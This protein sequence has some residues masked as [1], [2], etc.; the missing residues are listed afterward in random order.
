MLFLKK[1]NIKRKKGAILADAFIAMFVAS[2]LGGAVMGYLH[3]NHK[4]TESQLQ[5]VEAYNIATS[6]V[7]Q[8]QS[9]NLEEGLAGYMVEDVVDTDG[10]VTHSEGST[11]VSRM[12]TTEKG[13]NV[14][15]DVETSIERDTLDENFNIIRVKVM[16]ETDS[17]TNRDIVLVGYKVN[18]L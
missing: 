11:V 5:N 16:W 14:R 13:M 10:T 6:Y 9:A 2:V 4:M 12:N 3:L 8:M 17:G 7:E 18:E 15:Y 1:V